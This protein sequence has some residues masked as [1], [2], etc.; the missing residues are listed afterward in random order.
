MTDDDGNRFSPIEISYGF[1]VVTGRLTSERRAGQRE[2]QQENEKKRKILS[3][4]E[5]PIAEKI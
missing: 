5:P 2:G 4:G 3:H 1:F